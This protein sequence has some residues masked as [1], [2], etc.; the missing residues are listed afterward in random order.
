[1]YKLTTPSPHPNLLFYPAFTHPANVTPAQGP[2]SREHRC[3]QCPPLPPNQPV[4][5]ASPPARH[6]RGTHSPGW[7]G[8]PC[9]CFLTSLALALVALRAAP[10]IPRG[11]V[12]KNRIFFQWHWPLRVVTQSPLGTTIPQESFHTAATREGPLRGPRE[13]PSEALTVS[14]TP[15]DG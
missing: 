7:P 2:D 8:L 12:G 4:L 10:L 11:T 14:V 6:V 9:C 3:T 15:G 5:A 13:A 1:M